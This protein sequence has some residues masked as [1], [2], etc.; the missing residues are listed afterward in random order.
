[1]QSGPRGWLSLVLK[2][3][4]PRDLSSDKGSSQTIHRQGFV[5]GVDRT[6][7]LV[8]SQNAPIGFCPGVF[9]NDEGSPER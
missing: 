8:S 9:W 6:K 5:G 3:L 1:M 2:A 7:P 4:V